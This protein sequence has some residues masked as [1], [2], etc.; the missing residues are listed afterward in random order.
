MRV[1]HTDP[2]ESGAS[3]GRAAMTS[4]P[5]KVIRLVAAVGIVRTQTFAG[6]ACF[7]VGSVPVV[8]DAETLPMSKLA[9]RR[10]HALFDHRHHDRQTA[11]S[12]ELASVLEEENII[13]T[14]EDHA[15]FCTIL[16][17]VRKT[18]NPTTP[19]C[20][21]LRLRY[22]RRSAEH[23]AALGDAPSRNS[24]RRRRCAGT[25]SDQAQQQQTDDGAHRANS[26]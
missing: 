17:I 8:V 3:E 22:G 21:E 11:V 19:G 26:M 15:T 7:L 12:G 4:P 18:E 2:R 9:C 24:G 16:R 6:L 10:W 20:R 14:R 25:A 13:A 23:I 5:V 1:K